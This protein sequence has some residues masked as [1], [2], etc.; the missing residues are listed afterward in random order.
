MTAWGPTPF[1]DASLWCLWVP[2]AGVA[3]SLH[4][5]P[6]YLRQH[7][8]PLGHTCPCCPERCPQSQPTPDRLVQKENLGPWHH[9]C[10]WLLLSHLSLWHWPLVL[11]RIGVEAVVPPHL[12]PHPHTHLG[13]WA[14]AGAPAP[15]I[16][17]QSPLHRPMVTSLG[18]TTII[19]YMGDFSIVPHHA[20]SPLQS[21]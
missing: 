16:G 17:I 3:V 12:H 9:L 5:S 18:W 7:P 6:D 15:S 21:L 10:K 20:S 13:L 11:L 1:P 4:G 2:S 19:S 8:A 14:A